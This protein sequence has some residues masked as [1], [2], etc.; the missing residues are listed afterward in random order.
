MKKLTT[1][2]TSISE[3]RR[4]L[5]VFMNEWRFGAEKEGNLGLYDTLTAIEHDEE[6]T[7]HLSMEL[8]DYYHFKKPEGLRC[9]LSDIL[10]RV[11]R[12]AFVCMPDGEVVV[13]PYKVEKIKAYI[14]EWRQA[15]IV[16]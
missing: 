3:V 14:G 6:L 10:N 4:D 9:A 13:L 15:L 8:Y 2:A 12:T 7:R 11:A 1:N 5:L 16:E